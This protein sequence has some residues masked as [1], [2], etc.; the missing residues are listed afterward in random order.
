M[1]LHAAATDESLAAIGSLPIPGFR[2]DLLCFWLNQK[3]NT[4][5]AIRQY[6]TH[7][8]QTFRRMF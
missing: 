7:I 6:T 5:F 4:G 8:D 2:P 1:L 3:L